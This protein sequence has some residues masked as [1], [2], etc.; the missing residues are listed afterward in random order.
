MNRRPLIAV[1]AVPRVVPTG[2]GRRDADTAERGL[3]D[4]VTDSGATPLVLPV[5]AP[6]LA[7]SQLRGI[8]GLVLSGGQDLDARQF[9]AEPHPASTWTDPARDRHEVALWHAAREAHLPVLGICRGLQLAAAVNGGRL[10]PH[11]EG[12][13]AG[14]RFARIRHEVIVSPESELARA[15]G[16]GA[17]SVNTIH[18]QAVGDAPDGWTVAARAVDGTIE[19][20]ESTDGGWFLGVQWH[21]EL[22]RDEPGGQAVLDLLA[23]RAG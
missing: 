11:I 22:M 6:E 13:D 3:V 15:L 12:H 23:A 10:V 5:I 21:P 7:A 4:G 20:L 16:T 1:T 9:G 2:F 17:L 18:H 14:E 8:D 19:A